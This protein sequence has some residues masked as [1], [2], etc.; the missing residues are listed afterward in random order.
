MLTCSSGE[1]PATL[2]APNA[3]WSY[4]V[5]GPDILPYVGAAQ[6]WTTDG[7]PVAGDDGDHPWAMHTF[8][9]VVYDTARD[10]MVA[11]VMACISCSTSR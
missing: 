2:H 1:S 5:G 7:L 11:P 10:E 3:V 6:G 8:G 9:A 4:A